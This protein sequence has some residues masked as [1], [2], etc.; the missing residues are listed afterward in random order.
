MTAV[1]EHQDPHQLGLSASSVRRWATVFQPTSALT[2][3]QQHDLTAQRSRGWQRDA[4]CAQADP[5]AWFPEKATPARPQVFTVCGRCPV[6]RSCLAAALL[7]HEEGVWAGTTEADRR[8]LYA[9]LK[10]DIPVDRV[11]DAALASQS[12][13]SALLENVA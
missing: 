8:H 3:A 9:L 10:A 12:L 11:L 4:L 2:P 13:F 1:H 6:R 7:R 5:D